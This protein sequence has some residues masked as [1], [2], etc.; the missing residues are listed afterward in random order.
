MKCELDLSCLGDEFYRE[1]DVPNIVDSKAKI[2]DK[3]LN[4]KRQQG[5]AISYSV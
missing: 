1:S 3:L 5:F 2:N 4:D